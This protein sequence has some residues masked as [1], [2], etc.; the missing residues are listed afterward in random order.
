MRMCP[1]NRQ[2]LECITIDPADQKIRINPELTSDACSICQNCCP[3]GAISII[4]LPEELTKQPVHQYGENGFHL[5]NLPTPVFGQVIGILGRNG[6]GK[7]TAIKILAGVMKPNLGKEKEAGL[8]ELL[9]YF[10]GTESQLFF[11]KLAKGEIKVSYKPQHIDQIQKSGKGKVRDLLKKVDETGKM[12]D[13]VKALDLGQVLDNDLATISGGEMQRV[14][15]AATVLKKAQ[16]YVFDEP[17]SYLDIR[18]R[19]RVAKFIKELATPETAVLVVE[20]D[21]VILDYMTDLI[22]IVF[23]DEG[24]YGIVSLP[25]P[26]RNGINAYLEGFL[27]EQNLR[28]RESAITFFARPPGSRKSVQKLTNWPEMR[29]KLDKFSLSV[30]PG[31]VHSRSV[32]GVLGENGIGKTTFVKMLANVLK[33]DQGSVDT[34]V[35]V[36]YK[37]Q[38][39]EAGSDE[40]VSIALQEAIGKYEVALIRPLDLKRLL[41]KPMN[42]LSGGELQR[43]AIAHCL[44]QDAELFL[45]DEPSAYLDVEQRLA[46]A[47]TIKELAE[48][49][50]I[51]VLVV[52]HDLVF[53]DY[54]AD[55]LMVFT[56][57]PA[58]SGTAQGPFVM[59]EGMN[60][61]LREI[62]LTLRR[63]EESKRPRINKPGSRLDR[64]QKESG[65]LYYS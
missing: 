54:L 36:A 48:Q 39:L 20:H 2:G 27:K 29:K 12:D 40:L 9:A 58:R 43:V 62:D 32:V 50:N 64:E 65:K 45:L 59:E 38:Y 63:D 30:Q 18:Q 51:S 14:A 8:N 25:K 3:F 1:M 4:N 41:L 26:A 21:L 15:I 6:I 24:V 49:R 52:D 22:H 61:F 55:E 34:P 53:L 7:S 60:A 13:V 23:G 46:V 16:L 19:I 5:Y 56:G 35:K 37:P 57:T 17:T 11:E 10:K 33:P 44:S 28:F 47:K 31:G 42:T